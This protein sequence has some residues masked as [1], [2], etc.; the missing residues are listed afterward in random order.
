M[1]A[2]SQRLSL[3]VLVLGCLALGGCATTGAPDGYLREPEAAQ[4]DPYGAWIG[5]ETRSHLRVAG[6]FL[7]VDQ[8]SVYVLIG[9]AGAE[10][11]VAGVALEQVKHAKLAHFDPQTGK[12]S[13]W[14]TGGTL[15][16]ASHGIAGLVSM[17]LW[18]IIGSA[19][20][21]D[22][23][24]SA[25]EYYPERSWV[26]LQKYARFPQGVPPGM[27]EM[28]LRGKGVFEDWEAEERAPI[29]F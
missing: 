11:T 12:A 17:P 6:E 18:L 20:A 10:N 26:E 1:R 7:A 4:R 14:V 21:G 24:R 3:G 9:L 27:R 19:A 16:S 8:D 15:G 28:G 5:V 29:E 25:L 23:S 2:S 22:Q 13:M